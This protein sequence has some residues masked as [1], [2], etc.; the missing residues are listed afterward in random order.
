MT[1]VSR[2]RMVRKM[3]STSLVPEPLCQ[4]MKTI[5]SAPAIPMSTPIVF[6]PL[7][8][9]FKKTA[10]ISMVATGVSVAISEK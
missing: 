10:A 7:S 8:V 9:S 4:P 1:Q 5:K 3:P 6:F 2:L